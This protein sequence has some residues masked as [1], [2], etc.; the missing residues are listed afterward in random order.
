MS[1]LED[2]PPGDDNDW[3]DIGGERLRVF[4]RAHLEVQNPYAALSDARLTKAFDDYADAVGEQTPPIMR[5][6]QRA[7]KE[8]TVWDGKDV[9]DAITRLAIREGHM[10][11]L[12]SSPQVSR[13]SYLLWAG[14]ARLMQRAGYGPDDP[15][16]RPDKKGPD[17]GP[18]S[19][20]S[21]PMRPGG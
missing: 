4:S 12:G 11:G 20:P 21:R 15:V 7:L 6:M 19:A 2:Q 18:G 9:G 16:R 8:G 17:Q 5:A 14:A 13:E 1:A 10:Y 3:I